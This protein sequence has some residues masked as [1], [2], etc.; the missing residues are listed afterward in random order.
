MEF[1]LSFFRLL[2][3]FFFFSLICIVDLWA[4]FSPFFSPFPKIRNTG[5]YCIVCS[6][7]RFHHDIGTDILSFGGGG[8]IFLHIQRER[9]RGA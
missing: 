1:A 6:M 3:I 7:G 2:L 8:S 9:G 4:F 5:I